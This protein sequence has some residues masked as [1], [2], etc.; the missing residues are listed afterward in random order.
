MR[1]GP[2]TIIQA[3]PTTQASTN[4]IW[5]VNMPLVQLTYDINMPRPSIEQVA[6]LGG[7]IQAAIDQAIANFELHWRSVSKGSVQ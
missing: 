7:Q 4:D 5:I 6:A 1:V 2:V 3:F